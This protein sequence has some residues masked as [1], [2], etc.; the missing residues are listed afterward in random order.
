MRIEPYKHDCDRCIWVGW[1]YVKG[2]GK[3]GGD[4]GNMYYCPTPDLFVGGH[5]SVVI[6]FSDEPSDYW[7]SPVGVTLKG[8]LE[9]REEVPSDADKSREDA[10]DC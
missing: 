3:F 7:S 10:D 9:L 6:R 4:W 8:S 2:G 5:G 1:I